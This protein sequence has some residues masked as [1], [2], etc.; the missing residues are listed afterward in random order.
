MDTI[1]VVD[2]SY[3]AREIAG[4]CLKDHGV[5][6]VFAENGREALEIIQRDPPDAVLTDLNMPEM[7]G[8]ELV[9]RIRLDYP[10]VP[11]VL[12]TAHGSEQTAVAAL[13][14]GALSYVPK[15]N[16]QRDLC[17]AMMVVLHAVE[18]RRH[19]EHARKVLEK[20]ESHFVLGYEL[21][22]PAA[23]VSHLQDN[24]SDLNFCNDTVLFQVSTALTEAINNAVDH[25]NLELESVL[26]E[27]G[28]NAYSQLR[29]ERT[30]IEPY[31]GRKVR[32]ME[33]LTRLR[34]VRGARS[35]RPGKPPQG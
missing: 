2:D 20:Q 33:R 26:R 8:L 13:K 19:K 28:G 35:T 24:L 25:G 17:D 34:S 30:Q 32:V 23:L 31:R 16:L 18:S 12:M 6:A 5:K 22:S 3:L 11:V 21:E 29:Q 15:R 10:S 7:D 9:E 1:L 27:Q 4:G 14:A